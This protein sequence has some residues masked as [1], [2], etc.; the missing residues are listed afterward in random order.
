MSDWS[1]ASPNRPEINKPVLEDMD[2]FVDSIVEDLIPQ[3]VFEGYYTIRNV[4]PN[5]MV[6]FYESLRSLVYASHGIKHG[7]QE[8]AEE[9]YDEGAINN[10][11]IMLFRPD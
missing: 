3:L 1:D 8:L 7:L 2:R 4:P 9:I 5:E 10:D 6:L 11:D